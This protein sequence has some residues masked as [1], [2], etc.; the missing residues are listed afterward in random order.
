MKHGTDVGV[1]GRI[2]MSAC[3]VIGLAVPAVAE[4]GPPVSAGLTAWY[5]GDNVSCYG[6]DV[7]AWNDSATGDGAQS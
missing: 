5:Q 1:Y 2:L 3:C 4:V 7:I 6:G